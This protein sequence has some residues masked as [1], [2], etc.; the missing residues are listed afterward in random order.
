MAPVTRCI[1]N[2]QQDRNVAPT[3]LFEG[4]VAPLEPIDRVLLVLQEVWRGRFS[5][6]IGHTPNLPLPGSL[7][8][9]GLTVRK[10]EPPSLP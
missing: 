1:T 3:S 8:N 5:E 4:V 7:P 9:K 2:A 10:Q 6:P